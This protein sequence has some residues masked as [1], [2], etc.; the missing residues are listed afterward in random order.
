MSIIFCSQDDVEYDIIDPDSL[1]C[2]NASQFD[3]ISYVGML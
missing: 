2:K 3:L 1:T